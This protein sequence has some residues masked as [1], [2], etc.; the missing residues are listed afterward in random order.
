MA[1]SRGAAK[2]LDDSGQNLH[3][4]VPPVGGTASQDVRHL[5]IEVPGIALAEFDANGHDVM[6]QGHVSENVLQTFAEFDDLFLTAF[7]QRGRLM[8]RLFDVHG[9]PSHA[10]A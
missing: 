7:E 4:E 9:R 2:S 3:L 5:G 8:R 10:D 1:E 6:R